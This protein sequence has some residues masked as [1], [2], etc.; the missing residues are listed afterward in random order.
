MTINVDDYLSDLY[1]HKRQLN[2]LI[3]HKRVNNFLYFFS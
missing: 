3:F 1:V 2:Q